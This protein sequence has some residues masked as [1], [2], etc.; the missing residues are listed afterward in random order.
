MTTVLVLSHKPHCDENQ[1]DDIKYKYIV[2]YIVE[3]NIWSRE[4]SL[5]GGFKMRGDEEGCV[6]IN[7]LCTA[8]FVNGQC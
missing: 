3:I 7:G 6:A 1:K 8:Y 2:G 5:E 4:I